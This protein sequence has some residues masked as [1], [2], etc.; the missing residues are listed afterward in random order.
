MPLLPLRGGAPHL[1]EE[2]LLGSSHHHHN[3]HE[4]H[5]L[6]SSNSGFNG[7]KPVA[8]LLSSE[9]Q[10]DSPPFLQSSKMNLE[11]NRH[12]AYTKKK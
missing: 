8:L 12:N 6:N 11:K 4:Y 2:T 7:P 9:V 1:E 5:H 3:R 10:K